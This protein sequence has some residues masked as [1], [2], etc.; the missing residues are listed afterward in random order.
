[1]RI[2]L[3][4]ASLLFHLHSKF[5]MSHQDMKTGEYKWYMVMGGSQHKDIF[6][7]N[8]R[9]W[10]QIPDERAPNNYSNLNE[11][12]SVQRDETS[13]VKGSNGSVIA[14]L[15]KTAFVWVIRK[16][17]GLLSALEHISNYGFWRE[18]WVNPKTVWFTSHCC[19]TLWKLASVA[20]TYFIKP[21]D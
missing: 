19:Y 18:T 6:K 17:K 7:W 3:W 20:V 21:V 10:L 16:C 15:H 12:H 9:D 14:F 11:S 13:Y 4:L 5:K 2:W 1:M 8:D